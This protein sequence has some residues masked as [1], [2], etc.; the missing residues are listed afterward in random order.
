MLAWADKTDKNATGVENLP[1]TSA[2]SQTLTRRR[3][4]TQEANSYCRQRMPKCILTLPKRSFQIGLNG[5]GQ[6]PKGAALLKQGC[7]C[8]FPRFLA[9]LP[10]PVY[11]PWFRNI[12]RN[13]LAPITHNANTP[14]CPERS[15]PRAPGQRH[16]KTVRRQVDRIIIRDTRSLL[17][18]AS[19]AKRHL[20]RSRA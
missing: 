11:F 16:V 4:S 2:Y 7:F 13:C 10:T 12:L 3:G 9:T 15:P 5:E 17:S 6:A 8:V 20:V 14:P 19:M 18:V 1:E